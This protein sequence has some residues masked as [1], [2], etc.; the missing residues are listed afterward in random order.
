MVIRFIH[1]D[2]VSFLFNMVSSDNIIHYIYIYIYL[3]TI[4]VINHIF[5]MITNQLLWVC[6]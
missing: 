3:F 1:G 6:L 4:I 5:Q 2:V